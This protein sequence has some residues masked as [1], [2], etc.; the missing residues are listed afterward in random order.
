MAYRTS[1]RRWLLT[2][3]LGGCFL[4]GSACQSLRVTDAVDD[5][6]AASTAPA[7]TTISAA[8]VPFDLSVSAIDVDQSAAKSL[9]DPLV[10]LAVVENKGTEAASDIQVEGR[11]YNREGRELLLKKTES[12]ER[13]AAGESKVVRFKATEPLPLRDGYIVR[14]QAMPLPSELSLSNNTRVLRADVQFFAAR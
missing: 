12:V 1:M 9:R 7:V 10:L 6:V 4:L 13:L 3:G 14:V 8:P 2:G 11:L 5:P